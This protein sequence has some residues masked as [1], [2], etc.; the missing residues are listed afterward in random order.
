MTYIATF[1]RPFQCMHGYVFRIYPLALKSVCIYDTKTASGS[2]MRVGGPMK[3]CEG[4]IL[5]V[6]RSA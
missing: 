3:E 4:T 1:P 6:T 5:S 2:R